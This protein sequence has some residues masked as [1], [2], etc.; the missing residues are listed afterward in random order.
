MVRLAERNRYGAGRHKK[1][2]NLGSSKLQCAARII[3]D[4]Y[5]HVIWT[6]SDET[7][8]SDHDETE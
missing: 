1:S 6:V 2:L 3:H 7:S 4:L 5:Y 8:T